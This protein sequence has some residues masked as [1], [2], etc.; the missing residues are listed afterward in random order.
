METCIHA[1]EGLTNQEFGVVTFIFL[2]GI[3]LG[4]LISRVCQACTFKSQQYIEIPE[5]IKKRLARRAG[6]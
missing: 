4:F 6:V 5:S 3:A 1:I 2:I